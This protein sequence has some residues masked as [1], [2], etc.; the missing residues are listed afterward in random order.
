MTGIERHAHR[1]KVQ[2]FRRLQ[3]LVFRVGQRVPQTVQ[4]PEAYDTGI[5]RYSASLR[6]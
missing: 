1:D 2:H 4:W 6:V 5:Q 3:I